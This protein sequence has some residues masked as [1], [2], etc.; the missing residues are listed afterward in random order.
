MKSIVNVIILGLFIAN[1]AN[2]DAITNKEGQVYN[3]KKVMRTEPDGIT[4]MHDAGVIKLFFWELPESIQQQYGYDPATASRYNKQSTDAKAQ[5]YQQSI[6][7]RI[8][9]QA[10]AE[11]GEFPARAFNIKVSSKREAFQ[12]EGTVTTYFKG[13]SSY[14]YA[15][16]DASARQALTEMRTVYEAN[17]D[18]KNSR[19]TPLEATLSFGGATKKVSIP[20]NETLK[21]VVLKT[22]K[23]DSTVKITVEG[24]TKTFS[25]I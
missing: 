18:A 14:A 3:V 16:A 20:A 19:N 2:G 6:Q 13:D 25:R 1:A 17:F 23:Q 8:G 4:V 15:M 7:R 11:A 21:G 10:A 22:T 12:R 24:Q 5:A 9:A